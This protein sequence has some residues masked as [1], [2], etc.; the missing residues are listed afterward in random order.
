MTPPLNYIVGI[1]A[2]AGGLEAIQ[3]FF[4]HLPKTNELTFII[5]QH[6]S[7]DFASMMSEL[8]AQNTS[9][10]IITVENNMCLQTGVVYLIPAAFEA[11][12]AKN[13][14]KLSQ[15][16]RG[17]L[18]LP[19]DTLFTSIAVAYKKFSVGIILSGTGADGSL[20]MEEIARLGGLTLVQTPS[21]AKFADMPKQS[22]ATQEIHC[23][24]SVAEMPDVITEYINQPSEFNKNFK[25][26]E[27]LNQDDY[28]EIFHLLNEKYKINFSAYKLGT[29]SRRIQRRMQL[30]GMEKLQDYVDHLTNDDEGLKAL[31]QDTLIGVTKFFR[32]PEAF[33]ALESDVI[34]K[35]FAKLKKKN[36]EIRIWVNPC[37]TGEEA[38]SIAIL[39]KKYAS[40]HHLTPSIKLFASDVLNGFIQVAKKGCYSYASVA[41]LS[42]DILDNYFIKSTT[43]YEIIPEIRQHLLFTTHNLLQDPPFTKMDLVCCRNLLIY[44]NP[45]EQKRIT[46]LLRFSL[47]VGGFLFLGASEGIPSLEPDLILK[48]PTWKI[49]KKTKRSNFPINSA[50]AFTETLPISSAASI[51]FVPLRD[52]PLYAYNAI[53]NDVVSSGFI[54]DAAYT[55]LHSIGKAR[56]LLML[57]EGAP[58]LILP[59]III[60]DLKGALIAALHK[61]KH[62][63]IPVVYENITIHLIHGKKQTLQMAVHPICDTTGT[64][65][66]YWIRL[67]PVKATIKKQAKIVI[68]GS[69]RDAHNEEIIVALEGELSETRSLLQSSVERME[70]F[71][72]E[73]QSTNEELVASNEELQS[74]NEELQSVNEE[75]YTVNTERSKRMDEI[76]QAKTDIDNLIRGAEICTII[77]NN[78]LEIRIFT[79]AMEKIFNLVGHDVGRSLK[80]FRHNLKFD[81]LID[82]A[83]EVLIDNKPFET[84]V[85]NHQN[86][87]YF[88]KIT[89]YYSTQ[90]KLVTGIV[91][92][93]TDINDTKLLQQM[94]EDTEKNLRVA[95]KAGL[96]GIWHCNLA[97]NAF[98]YDETIKTIFGLNTLSSMSQ[99]KRFIA[100]VHLD[101]RKRLEKAFSETILTNGN[102]EQNFRITRPDK[103]VR[104]VSCSANIHND[105]LTDQNYLSGICWDMTERYWLEE[106]IIDAEHLNL[107]L[108]AITDGWW[109]WNL[110]SNEIY[111][112]P[113]LKKTLGYEDHELANRIE[114]YER[115]MFPDDLKLMRHQ[116]EKY[117]A[118]NSDQPITQKLKMKHKDSHIV[119][120][121]SRGKGILDRHKK[122]V[123]VVGTHTDITALKENEATLEQLAYRDSLTQVPNRASLLDEL[124]RAIER[125]KRNKSILAVMFLD[126]D[127]FKEINDNNGHAIGDAV[128]CAVTKK[129]TNFSRI[130][131]FL[132]RL[133]GDEFAILLEDIVDLEEIRSIASR[134]IS[135]FTEPL[136]ING[137]PMLITLSIGIALY[138][139]HGKSDKQILKYA[140]K[141]MY[142]AK[143]RGKN[144]F[145]V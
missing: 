123:R 13:H 57:P 82:R 90:K 105:S 98:T 65:S 45:K 129:L 27:P 59:K 16:N 101:D 114:S 143:N 78:N 130:V 5:M 52:L 104:Y 141:N 144:Q 100:A 56:E 107:G 1:G 97:T 83:E 122:L 22:I 69:Q 125:A 131:D 120:I 115:L 30:L 121:L 42:S 118:N 20:G 3:E 85:K 39:F 86:Y 47:N 67:S 93:L 40:E 36:E 35:L 48:N 92:T 11:R 12:V 74:T 53:L 137:T 44:I 66:Y 10:P 94:K 81:H 112:S 117:V 55:V 133:G 138:P 64:V 88:L 43:H 9:M 124:F 17:S 136:N 4:N 33:A 61:V 87:W 91:I 76:N 80:N 41:H 134:Y 46:D 106:K 73:I 29:I 79:P 15:L 108:D 135:A 68:S 71:N 6:L 89:P 62:S 8:L 103:S 2:S 102:F 70:T 113:L 111:L 60:D 127:N 145:V 140:D 126:I 139:E 77:L 25:Q 109:D 26:I 132:A 119:W 51:N 31:Y 54:I 96:I 49:F 116:F 24:L 58:S 38:Y 19:I 32:D 72:E 18:S 7:P 37:S 14:F 28:S 95:L 99:F 142:I 34:P 84:E 21:E 110:L 50:T 128:L 75:L 63:L 23:V